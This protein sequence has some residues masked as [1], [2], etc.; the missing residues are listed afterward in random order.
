MFR[1]LFLCNKPVI[2]KTIS[3]ISC[4]FPHL[5]GHIRPT[6]VSPGWWNYRAMSGLKAKFFILERLGCKLSFLHSEDSFCLNQWSLNMSEQLLGSPMSCSFRDSSDIHLRVPAPSSVDSWL[7]PSPAWHD[8]PVQLQ[9]SSKSSET[10]EEET[11]NVHHP[12]KTLRTTSRWDQRSIRQ[13]WAEVP[14]ERGD[15]GRS[16]SHPG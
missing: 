9:P 13:R 3:A 15:L 11:W 14:D 7:S 1:L 5:L 10:E 8:L 12:T 6:R 16:L 4:R 2:F